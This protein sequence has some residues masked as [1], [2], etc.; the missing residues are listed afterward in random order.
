MSIK[1]VNI[2]RQAQKMMAKAATLKQKGQQV[3]QVDTFKLNCTEFGDNDMG[4]TK[5]CAYYNFAHYFSP[6]FIQKMTAAT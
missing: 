2:I 3:T 6:L 1:I 5:F 4:T